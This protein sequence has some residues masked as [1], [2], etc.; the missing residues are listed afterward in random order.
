MVELAMVLT[1]RS[2]SSWIEFGLPFIFTLYSKVP[3]FAVPAGKMRFCALIAFTTSSGE[4]P[5]A[6]RAAVFRST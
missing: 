2:F 3:I 5:F 6:C 4:S 1:G